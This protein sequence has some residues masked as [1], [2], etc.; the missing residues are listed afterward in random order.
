MSKCSMFKKSSK[1]HCNMTGDVGNNENF[2][3]PNKTLEKQKKTRLRITY[4]VQP[5]PHSCHSSSSTRTGSQCASAQPH[6]PAAPPPDSAA[7]AAAAARAA[8][9]PRD[10]VHWVLRRA[11]P[12]GRTPRRARSPERGTPGASLRRRTTWFRET[13]THAATGR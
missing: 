6:A 2:I 5:T 4:P 12:A 3:R 9:A 13:S 10:G 7:A 8:G 11:L 1:K